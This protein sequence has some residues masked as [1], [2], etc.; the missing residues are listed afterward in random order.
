VRLTNSVFR[1]VDQGNSGFNHRDIPT[2]IEVPPLTLAMVVGGAILVT[3]RAPEPPKWLIG[4]LQGDLHL[5]DLEVDLLNAPG[6]GQAKQLF[7]ELY[8]LHDRRVT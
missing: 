6:S 5:L 2:D 4:Q 1:A 3:V 7:I 8:I